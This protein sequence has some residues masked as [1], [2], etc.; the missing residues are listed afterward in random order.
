MP[1]QQYEGTSIEKH[2]STM[3]RDVG[4]AVPKIRCSPTSL[5]QHVH[6]PPLDYAIKLLET[7]L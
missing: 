4:M 1:E 2:F 7:V 5:F 3:Y 6:H